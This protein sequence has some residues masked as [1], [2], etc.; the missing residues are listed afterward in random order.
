MWPLIMCTA[1]APSH[2]AKLTRICRLLSALVS[3]RVCSRLVLSGALLSSCAWPQ[4]ELAT[5]FG[6]VTDQ[7]GAVIPT[8]RITIVNQITGFKRNTVTAMNGEYHLTGL[9]AGNYV[10][11]AES[12]GFRAQDQEGVRLSP[13]SG[14]IL[15]F[16]LVVGSQPQQVTVRGDTRPRSSHRRT[17]S[18]VPT[19]SPSWSNR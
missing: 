13:A 8:A 1:N 5:V 7:S 14:V 12:P 2:F 17:T 18:T 9:P 6:T 15:N 19:R 16:S 10:V 3:A 4:S 11:H